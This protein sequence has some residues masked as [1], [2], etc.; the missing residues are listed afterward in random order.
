LCIITAGVYDMCKEKRYLLLILSFCIILFS[1]VNIVQYLQSFSQLAKIQDISEITESISK[2]K[3]QVIYGENDITPLLSYL[4]HTPMLGNIVDTN[5]NIFRKG[6]LNKNSMT[7]HVFQK[8][9]MVLVHGAYY[10]QSGIDQKVVCGIVDEN[11]IE[12]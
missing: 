12:K 9:T 8:K 10:P 7:Q 11:R 2:N 4:T 5:E 1:I 6:I 3:P